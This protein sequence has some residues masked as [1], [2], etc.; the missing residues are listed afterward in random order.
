MGSYRETVG[1]P[2][3]N[4]D[5]TKTRDYRTKYGFGLSLEQEINSDLGIFSRVSWNDGHE[6]S[7]AFSEIDQSETFGASLKGTRWHRPSDILGS[8]V[9]VNH[10]SSD[11]SAYLNSGGY[12]FMLGDSRLS[13]N[14][15][16][17]WETYY[18]FEVM[19]QTFMSLDY[20]Y[21]VNP[22]YNSDRGPISIYGFRFH[23]EI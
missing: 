23:Y 5:I 22:A 11:H 3:Y 19:K 17:I 13:Y 21:V 16:F 20:S 6:E 2:V 7:W 8:S 10:I 4:S 14:P 18:S 9:I 1:N 15:E 12:G